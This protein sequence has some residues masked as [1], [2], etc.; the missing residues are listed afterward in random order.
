MKRFNSFIHRSI[1]GLAILF[2]CFVL[3][4]SPVLG[5]DGNGDS[6]S[7]KEKPAVEKPDREKL[8]LSYEYPDIDR[9]TPVER[10]SVERPIDKFFDRFH[11]EGGGWGS[12]HVG[13]SW[14]VSGF[15]KDGTKGLGVTKHFGGSKDKSKKK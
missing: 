8:D 9:F 12:Y 1:A 7:D 3:A 2:L 10:K 15:Y 6:K 5:G 11:K 14:D 4:T 13:K